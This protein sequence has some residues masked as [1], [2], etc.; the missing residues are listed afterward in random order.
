MA[1]TFTIT[2]DNGDVIKGELYP[3]KAPKTKPIDQREKKQVDH[4]LENARKA[5]RVLEFTHTVF[6]LFYF[7]VSFATILPQRS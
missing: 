2:M 5:K 6:F 1:K 7:S 4:G 3:D